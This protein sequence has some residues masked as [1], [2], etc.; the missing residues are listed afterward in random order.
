M[1][2]LFAWLLPIFAAAPAVDAGCVKHKAADCALVHAVVWN[3]SKYNPKLLNPEKTGSYGLMQIQCGTA[4]TMGFT[5]KCSKLFDPDTNLSIGIA[6]LNE[7]LAAHKG[8]RIYALAAYNA[9]KVYISRKT[10]RLVNAQYVSDVLER[11]K[12]LRR[13]QAQFELATYHPGPLLAMGGI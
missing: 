7:R 11:Y 5:G 4:R 8:N 2:N 13:A 10:G 6:Y 9:G 12:W 1:I 3:E